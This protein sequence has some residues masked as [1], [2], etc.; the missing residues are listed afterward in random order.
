MMTFQ[1]VQNHQILLLLCIKA[2]GMKIKKDGTKASIY[3]LI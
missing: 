2:S 3:M 1:R